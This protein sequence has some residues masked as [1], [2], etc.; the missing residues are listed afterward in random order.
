MDLPQQLLL[1]SHDPAR[2]RL[3]VTSALVR[4]P[5]LRAAAVAELAL[6]GLLRPVDRRVERA[7][8]STPGDPF[9][10]AVLDAVPADRPRSW[11]EVIDEDFDRAEDAVLDGLAAAGTLRTVRA[12]TWNLFPVRRA[13]LAD[14][15]RATALRERVRGAVLGGR[16][17]RTEDAV[18]AL[19]AAD[20]GVATTFGVR[21]QHRHR[22]AFA[23][24]AGHVESRLPGLR[25]GT[26]WSLAA[27]RAEAGGPRGVPSPRGHRA[28]SRTIPPGPS[29]DRAARL[30][31]CSPCR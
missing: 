22:G 24:V 12:R 6:R 3:D 17:L 1:L 7:A 11:F 14:P 28:P 31:A 23:A 8:G 2:D 25:M 30:R 10:T 5:L 19:L 9:L 15:A 26:L 21:E 4:G 27:R 20:G 13:V 16:D 18:L 29:T